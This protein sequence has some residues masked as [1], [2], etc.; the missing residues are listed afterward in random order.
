MNKLIPSIFYIL[1]SLFVFSTPALAKVIM[2]EKGTVTIPAG[3]TI[4]DDLFIAA[5]SVVIHGTITGDVFVGTGDLNVTGAT[6]GDSLIVGAGNVNI[7]KTSKIGGSLIVGAGTLRNYAPVSRNV[8]VGAGTIYLGSKV[9]KEARLGGGSITLGENTVIAGNLTYALEEGF[10]LSQSPSATIAGS[11]SRFTPPSDSL[12]DMAKAKE[13]FGKFS[14][15]AHRGWLAISFLGSLLLG[16]LLLH[17]F[18]KSSLSLSQMVEN[19]LMRSLGIGFLMIVFSIPVMLVLAIS[20][21]GLPI[22]GLLIPLFMVCLT[23]AKLI[24]SYALGRFAARQ[25]NWNKMGTYT[26]F[27]IGLAVF[28]LLR[29]LPGIGWVTT[30]LFTW[31]GLG[32]FWIYTR[33]HLKSL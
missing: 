32:S 28:Y 21:I 20:V 8:M 24:S 27:F 14:L 22:V 25:F 9:G 29:A 6:I 10:Q 13:D 26:V 7:D 12:R 18:P 3:E 5:E 19:S 23:L 30:F 4:D 16:F 1:C 2:Q 15:V 11:I 17:F 33:S 31:V